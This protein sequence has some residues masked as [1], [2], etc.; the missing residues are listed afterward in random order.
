MILL[1]MIEMTCFYILVF[2]LRIGETAYIKM[3]RVYLQCNDMCCYLGTLNGIS[4][5]Q[6][7]HDRVTC[8]V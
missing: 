2:A 1:I 6:F 7:Y 3:S 8:Y 4:E 5:G